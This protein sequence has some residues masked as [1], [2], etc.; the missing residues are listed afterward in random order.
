MRLLMVSP[1]YVIRTIRTTRTM[2]IAIEN[3]S[4]FDKIENAGFF[5]HFSLA[6][7]HTHMRDRNTHTTAKKGYIFFYIPLGRDLVDCL[8]QS[9]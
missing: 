7:T 4:I 5:S 3:R 8:P 9:T 6:Q 1:V 2:A